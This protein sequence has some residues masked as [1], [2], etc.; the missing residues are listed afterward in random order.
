MKMHRLFKLT[1]LFLYVQITGFVHAIP[2][3]V[4]I[5]FT[6]QD[7]AKISTVLQSYFKQVKKQLLVASYWI[8]DINFIQRLI[9]LKK[10]G[11]DVQVI[12]DQSTGNNEKLTQTLLAHGIIPV[13]SIFSI[14]DRFIKGMGLMHNKFLIVDW[15]DVWTGS[16][17]FTKRAFNLAKTDTNNENI[18]TITSAAVADKYIK[19]FFHIESSIF[20]SYIQTLTNRP[21]NQLPQWLQT[22]VVEL[23]YKN[24]RFKQHLLDSLSRLSNPQ[25]RKLISYLPDKASPKISNRTGSITR[26]QLNILQKKHINA[27]GLSKKEAF[28]L[29]AAILTKES[30]RSPKRARLA[31]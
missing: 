10:R 31:Y 28:N 26:S 6:P 4:N 24:P 3:E 19:N 22:L 17:N 11:I 8:T 7:T 12:Y 5:Y 16:A 25:L 15:V 13:V 23:Y 29:I 27:E 21:R 18:V 14:Q 30:E 2:A 20:T 9:D 1:A